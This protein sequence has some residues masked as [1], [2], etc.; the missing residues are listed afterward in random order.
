[1]V[2]DANDVQLPA[3]RFDRKASTRQCF[4]IIDWIE[5]YTLRSNKCLVEIV[6]DIITAR[7]IKL[8]SA[9]LSEQKKFPHQLGP[10]QTA[11]IHNVDRN[12][13]PSISSSCGRRSRSS[14]CW[15]PPF[16]PPVEPCGHTSGT[17]KS[18]VRR[19][20]NNTKIYNSRWFQSI[21]F[22]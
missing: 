1:M 20:L 12:A 21:L 17:C 2:I 10:D 13:L 5:C 9:Q 8:Y 19:H 15:P 18:M 3:A 4:K 16:G 7:L 11:N 6:G 22:Q 14:R